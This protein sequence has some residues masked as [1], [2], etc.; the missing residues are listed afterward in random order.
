MNRSLLDDP[1]KY[2]QFRSKIPVGRWGE[3]S[4]LSAAILFLCSPANSFMTG[5]CLTI[6]GGW[7]AQ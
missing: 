5:S 6:D 7:T 1:V 4:E 2:E 3:I